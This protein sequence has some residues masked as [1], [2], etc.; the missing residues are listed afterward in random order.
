MVIASEGGHATLPGIS[1]REDAIINC[2]RQR[3]GHVSAERAI[4]GQGLENLYAAIAAIDRMAAPTR[5]APE[6]TRAALDGSCPLSVIS[7]DMFCAMLGTVAGDV[8][9]MF[10]ARGGVFIAGGIAPRILDFIA[11]SDFRARFEAK[12]RF[13]RYVEAV[14][15]SVIVH[16]EAT[17]I[18]L[19]A[20]AERERHRI[21]PAR[22]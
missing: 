12:G 10:G 20:I 7:L 4:S 5:N 17:F 13:R 3:F 8:A 11:R 16:P 2:L 22:A 14:P 6:I 9:L 19:K 15:S 1:P 21:T 18:G